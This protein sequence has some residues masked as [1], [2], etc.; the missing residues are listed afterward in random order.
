[1]KNA[2]KLTIG[3]SEKGD[4]LTLKL[5]DNIACMGSPTHLF[6]ECIKQYINMYNAYNRI[7]KEDSKTSYEIYVSYYSLSYLQSNKHGYYGIGL[8]YSTS[9]GEYNPAASGEIVIDR[10]IIHLTYDD[11]FLDN[12][13]PYKR[14]ARYMDSSIWNYYI[15]VLVV[16]EKAIELDENGKIRPKL[17]RYDFIPLER[18]LNEII[19]NYLNNRYQLRVAREYA[20]LFS[21]IVNQ[22]FLPDISGHGKNVSPY[23][24]HSERKSF[25]DLKKKEH[26]DI[27][28]EIKQY[29]WRFLLVDDHSTKNMAVVDGSDTLTKLDIVKTELEKLFKNIEKDNEPVIISSEKDTEDIKKNATIYIE[30]ATSIEDAKNKLKEKKYEVI[31]L[32]Y[33]LGEKGDGR[34]YGYE[35]LKGI[36]Y[37]ENKDNLEEERK[38]ELEKSYEEYVFD[39]KKGP[40]NLFFFMFISAFTTAVSERLLTEGWLR[41][42]DYCWY[43]GEGACPINT[44]YLFQYRLLHIMQKRM[45]KMKLKR[46]E[47]DKYLKDKIYG[48]D[49]IRNKAREKFKEVLN[50]MCDYEQ[51]E[52][53]YAYHK[54]V[55]NSAE[56]VMV[57]NF[58]GE[59]LLPKAVFE[60]VVQLVYLTAFGTVRQWPEM[61]EEYQFIKSVVGKI[62]SV[63]KYIF[64]LK[65]NNI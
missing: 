64:N 28:S 60:H 4:V 29:K 54:N 17:G 32:D 33:L 26:R 8:D 25:E 9:F 62:D 56:S 27:L 61:W 2:I 40:G 31:L 39:Y 63:E 23:L 49:G 59:K 38:K 16:D 57:T 13:E 45:T 37:K 55:F 10:P 52:A 1:M 65:N 58:L 18:A 5:S 7:E 3:I 12:A 43:I 51:L 47:I 35:L 21:R 44:P 11:I 36:W 53:D 20:H 46:F 41:N 19:S 22:S 48:G 6:Y 24:F 14:Y 30:C 15:P 50:F 42:E 34:E